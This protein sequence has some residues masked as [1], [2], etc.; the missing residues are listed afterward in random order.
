MITS[1]EQILKAAGDSES[2]TLAVAA[3]HDAAVLRAVV[4]A[5]EL[6]LIEAVLFGSQTTIEE[7]AHKENLDLAPFEI[8][9]VPDDEHAAAESV[10]AIHEGRAAM[11]MKGNLQTS[12]LLSAVLDRE[13]GLRIDG[14][15]IAHV[16]AMEIP[17]YE[18]LLIVTDAAMNIAPDLSTKVSIVNSAVAI[19]HAL[20]IE[21]PRVAV[22]AAV[23]VV[24]PGM[25]ATT[26]AAALA[27]M[28]DRGQIGGCI[29]DGPFAL[30]NAVSPEAA[31]HKRLGGS[32]AGQ[33]DIL[34]APDIEAGNVLYK[35]ITFLA[36]G[37]SA[38]VVVGARAPIVLTSR[39]DTEESKLA[40]IA[41]AALASA[42]PTG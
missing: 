28:N 18:R 38:G 10:R 6:G 5:R 31:R 32:V 20:G 7:I 35:S 21:A 24:N 40:S 30:D 12:L 41:L 11:L 33:A 14:S 16:A 2:R 36:R 13:S 1:M 39:S 34:L 37:R 19:A 22:L 3:A 42:T 9:D 27:K 23:E 25:P 4:R 17:G 29:V 26:D 8:V 15:V